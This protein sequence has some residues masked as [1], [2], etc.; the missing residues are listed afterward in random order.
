MH[1]RVHETLLKKNSSKIN[2]YDSNDDLEKLPLTTL[3]RRSTNKSAGFSYHLDSDIENQNLIIIS[4][5]TMIFEKQNDND[6]PICTQYE[7]TTNKFDNITTLRILNSLSLFILVDTVVFFAI[8]SFTSGVMFFKEFLELD[9]TI[10]YF[11]IN[12]VLFY[13]G[14]FLLI[15]MY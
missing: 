15:G 6:N 8:Y 4:K 12:A 9:Q 7:I 3:R 1:E 14:W 13:F 11:Q 10:F 5:G 2:S